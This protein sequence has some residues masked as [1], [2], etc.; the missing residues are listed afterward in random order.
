[1]DAD[2]TLDR[3][4]EFLRTNLERV[5]GLFSREAYGEARRGLMQVAR[6]RSKRLAP[7]RKR[8]RQGGTNP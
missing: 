5:A 3:L 1:M 7:S 4:L 8:P 2:V 6:E